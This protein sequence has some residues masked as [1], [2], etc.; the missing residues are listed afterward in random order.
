[1]GG[2]REQLLECADQRAAADLVAGATDVINRYLNNAGINVA[3]SL[4]ARALIARGTME[5]AA[6]WWSDFGRVTHED[7]AAALNDIVANPPKGLRPIV[8]LDP[9][10]LGPAN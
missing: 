9:S 8:F 3:T 2:A 1:M 6:T 4:L 7:A 5:V 10:S